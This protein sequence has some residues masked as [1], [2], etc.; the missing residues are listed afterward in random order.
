MDPLSASV[1]EPQDD[2]RHAEYIE[3]ILE[4]FSMLPSDAGGKLKE[5]EARSETFRLLRRFL[6]A[7]AIQCEQQG[8]QPGSHEALSLLDDAYTTA[9]NIIYGYDGLPS[10]RDARKIL[11]PEDVTDKLRLVV[12]SSTYSLVDHVKKRGKLGPDQESLSHAVGHYVSGP[13][14]TVEIDRILLQILTQVEIVAYIDEM[15]WENPLTGTS[16]LQD[17]KPLGPIRATWNVLKIGFGLWVMCLAFAF[18]PLLFGILPLEMMFII[19]MGVG[20]LG[21]LILLILLVVALVALRSDRPRKLKAQGNILDMIKRMDS[22]YREFRSSGPISTSHFK[23][24]VN[25][26]AEA[27]VI[28]PSGLYVLLDDIE[29]RGVRAV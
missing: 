5:A 22:F 10:S 8:L 23:K 21:S 25:D 12:P 4:G 19:G 6:E 14:K 17:A 28:W 20:L 18:S 2:E 3:N 27:G 13:F 9:T 11:S 26:L 1:S 29:A 24:R 16:R 7:A 15:I